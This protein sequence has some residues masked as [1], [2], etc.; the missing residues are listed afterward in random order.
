MSESPFLRQKKPAPEARA[1]AKK[2]ATTI[3]SKPVAAKAAAKHA[4]ARGA[5]LYRLMLEDLARS[6]LDAEDAKTMRLRPCEAD[7]V[8]DKLFPVADGYIIPY[9][10]R[11]GAPL[12]QMYRYRFLGDPRSKGFARMGSQ[13]SRRYTQPAGSPPEVYWPPFTHWEHIATDP[14]VPLFVT[15]GEK[16]AAVATKFGMPCIGLGGVWSFRSK[17]LGVRLLPELQSVV[18]EGRTAILAYDSDAVLNRDVCLAENT[19]A[20]ELTRQGAVVKILRLP[21]LIEDSKC[22]LDDYLVSEGVDRMV[23]LVA[24]TEPY[25]MGRELHVMNTEVIYVQNPG[26]VYVWDDRNPVRPSDFVAHRFADRQY[27]HTSMDAKGNTKMEIRQTAPDWLKWPQRA[28]ATRFV[29]SP[30]EDIITP[31]R[32]LNL[33]K[34]WAYQPERGTVKPWTDLLDFIFRGHPEARTYVEQWAAYPVQ[35]PGTKLRNA[36]AIW[37]LRKGTGKSLIGYTL[38]DLY[39]DAFYEIDDSHID[40]SNGFN[41]WARH[42]HFVLGDEI[43]GN[44]SRRVANRIKAMITREKVEINIKNLPQYTIVDCINFLFTANAPDCFYL[45]EDDRRIFIHEVRG[46]PLADEFYAEYDRWRR[47]TAGRQALMW[48]LLYG[49]NTADFNPMAR[50]P[51]SLAKLEMIRN[52]RTELEDWLGALRSHPDMICAKFGS[53]DLVSGSEIQILHEGDGHKRVS[54]MLLARKLKELGIDPLYPADSPT[55]PQIFAGGK[56][57]RLY[58]LRNSAKWAKTDTAGIREY[59][60]RCR[61][62]RQL[63]K[64]KF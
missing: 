11:E 7:E 59:Y 10:T 28:V 3:A 49:V 56:L 36:V 13:K 41:E 58:A 21:E 33:W 39:G 31:R 27:T 4:T 34:G 16:K 24:S 54:S 57:V 19:L 18:W 12:D 61:G 1:R 26:I 60:E 23:E 9:F 63:P 53:C 40:G 55:N 25:S 52:T 48:H 44:D 20:E 17:S 35:Y 45:E 37:G 22:G 62:I 29:F 32:E 51:E 43:T 64:R 14:A 6:G 30:S 15:E 38:G 8:A 46:A 5:E 47:S 50:P 42:R 2:T